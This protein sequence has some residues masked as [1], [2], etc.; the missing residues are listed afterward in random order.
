MVQFLVDLLRTPSPTGYHREAMDVV[1]QAFRGLEIDDLAIARN[2]KGALILTWPGEQVDRPRGLTAHTDTLGLMVKEVKPNGRL[3][4]TMLGGYMWNAVEFEAVTVQ[5]FDGQRYR[6]TVV[7][8]KASVHVHSDARDAPR[9]ADT[10]E[11]RLDARVS[12]ADETRALGIDVGDF[13]FL[14]PRVEVTDTGFIRSRH[15]DDKAGVAAIFGAFGALKAAGL[16]PAQRLT[17]V[18]ANYEEVGHGGAAGLPLELHEL[19]AVDMAAVGEGQNSD[20]YSVGICAKDAGGPYHTDL[21]RKLRTLAD[22]AGIPYKVDIYPHYGSD[23][24]AYWHAGGAAQVAL[25]GPGVDASHA[26][27]R[28][29]R[30]SLLHSAHL[31][32]RFVLS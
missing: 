20:E 1:E 11:V 23:G 24:E 22:K 29:H 4:L 9:N 8:V 27:E 18:I 15:L 28:T 6:G 3:K 13:V 12:S 26:Y 21:T 19:V 5:T 17:T 31:I 30:E 16:R 2:P 32:A 14:D 25:I 7:P 10:M